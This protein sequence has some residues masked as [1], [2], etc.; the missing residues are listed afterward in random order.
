MANGSFTKYIRSGRE[1]I[2]VTWKSTPIN[3]ENKSKVEVYTKMYRPYTLDS[4]ANKTVVTTIN[5]VKHT[6]TVKGWGGKG[7]TKAF[8]TTTQEVS[9]GSNGK[10]TI[11]ISVKVEVALTLTNQYYSSVTASSKSCKLD[12]LST[13]SSISIPKSSTIGDSLTVT[14][15]RSSSKVRHSIVGKIGKETFTILNK[16]DDNGTAK[17]YTKTLSAA[18]FLPMMTAKSHTVDIVCTT[19][20]SASSSTKLGTSTKSFTLKLR[21]SDKPSLS[22]D[23]IGISCIPVMPNTLTN[24]FVTNYSFAKLS[25]SANTVAGSAGAIKSYKVTIIKDGKI[26]MGNFF[27]GKTYTTSSSTLN[28]D[29]FTSYGKHNVIVTAIDKRGMESDPITKIITVER[30]LPPSITNF[31]VVRCDTDGTENKQGDSVKLQANINTFYN[32]DVSF[33]FIIQVSAKNV[34]DANYSVI[35]RI[36]NCEA[37]DDMY[38]FEKI[39]NGYSSDNSFEFELKVTDSFGMTASYSSEIGTEELLIDL[40]PHGVAI[41]KVSEKSTEETGAF[42]VGWDAYFEGDIIIGGKSLKELL[43]IT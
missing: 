2:E 38:Y 8:G 20:Q 14:L 22:S 15:N 19:Y 10:K 35:D 25:L 37:V 41:G 11:E 12:D 17:S 4:S 36:E 1:K 26:G 16:S 32:S 7:W 21:D 18:T 31:S 33:P 23:N 34:L 40:A 13:K 28:S 5:G 24:I 3:G 9:H 30:Y 43:K 29:I 39:Y 42:E 27:T 6:T